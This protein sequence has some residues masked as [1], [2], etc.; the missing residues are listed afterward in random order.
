MSIDSLNDAQEQTLPRPSHV[1]RNVVFTVA[2]AVGSGISLF[3]L[4]RY[5]LTT[6]GAEQVGVW[7]V[8]AAIASVSKLS[9]LGFAGG[10][11]KYTATFL[12]RND[13]NAASAVIQTTAISIAAILGCALTIGHP[14]AELAIRTITPQAQIQNAVS[15]V[16]I[17]LFSVW[18]ASISGAFMAG[19]DGCQRADLRSTISLTCT[20]AFLALTLLLVPKLGLAGLAFA[21]VGQAGLM[22]VASLVLLRRELP[23]FPLFPR[24]WKFSI[25]RTMFRY[26]FNFQI[27]SIVSLLFDPTTKA[28]LTIFGGLSSTAY[29]E[30]AM[31]MVLQF[32]ALLVSANQALVPRIATLHETSPTE[33]RHAYQRTYGVVF[34]FAMPVFVMIAVASP[35]A[36]VVWIGHHENQFVAFT[37]VLAASYWINTLVGPSYFVNLGTGHMRA[38]V[39][40]HL[41]IGILNGVVGYLLGSSLGGVGVVLGYAIALSVGSA[42]VALEFHLSESIP[43]RELLP[44]NSA[45]LLL[46]SGIG[47]LS[48]TVIFGLH[49]STADHLAVSTTA[50]VVCLVPIAFAC[51]RH[52][53]KKEISDA[54]ARSLD[55]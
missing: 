21:Q 10:A 7:A 52:P 43:F 33:V 14:V 25:F 53:M 29:Y 23:I 1:A 51:W 6:L 13:S 36:S 17:A 35:A 9:E 34:Y 31:R 28:L 32:R 2:N 37:L 42:L 22:L 5:L 15:I 49:G 39:L 40:S 45:P 12:S 24:T 4:Y 11:V 50:M 46:A 20:L 48:A 38:N 26:S 55:R 27:I 18:L 3:F 19:L 8:V 44:A 16:P 30:M 41:L 54:L 47:V